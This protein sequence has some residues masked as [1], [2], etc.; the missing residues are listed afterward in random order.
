[1]TRTGSLFWM[2]LALETGFAM[3]MVKY[4]VQNLEDNLA[5]I[6]KQTVSEQLE[7]RVLNAEWS[8]L[9][10]PE[11]LAGLNRQLLSLAPITPKQLE[12][13]IAAIPYRTPEPPPV[14]AET[15]AA[16]IP[17]A[18]HLSGTDAPATPAALDQLFA[19][20]AGGR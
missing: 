5:R 19:Q 12:Q 17:A 1:M 14:Q 8:Y 9:T 15:V 4:A 18:P 3:F 11:R 20:I 10:Q 2:A 7:I 16:T 13:T 6:R